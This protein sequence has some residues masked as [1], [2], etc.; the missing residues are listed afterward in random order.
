MSTEPNEYMITDMP[1]E[2]LFYV[3]WSRNSTAFAVQTITQYAA[4]IVYYVSDFSS[5]LSRLTYKNLRDGLTFGGEVLPVYEIDDLSPDGNEVLFEAGHHLLFWDVINPS[6]NLILA[7]N[8]IRHAAIFSPDSDREV[9]YLR[10]RKRI[11]FRIM[12]KEAAWAGWGSS[13]GDRYHA[14]G[15]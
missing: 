6:E 3:K 13:T 10:A 5:S 14:L 8:V 7:E 11:S 12:T 2:Q 1:V 4:Y 15:C 9:M